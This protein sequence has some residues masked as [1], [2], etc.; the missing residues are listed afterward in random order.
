[1]NRD[2]DEI[3]S[4]LLALEVMTLHQPAWEGNTCQI[5]GALPTKMNSF[6]SKLE[7]MKFFSALPIL[8]AANDQFFG[9]KVNLF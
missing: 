1:L 4:V 7:K 9:D 3:S 5:E 8:A 2:N 6:H